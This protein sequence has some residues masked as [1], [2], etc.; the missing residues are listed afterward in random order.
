MDIWDFLARN[1]SN[2][3]QRYKKWL[4][5][6]SS[7]FSF[8]ELEDKD[9]KLVKRIIRSVREIYQE[10]GR[11]LV[12]LSSEHFFLTA[13]GEWT[14]LF[15][16]HVQLEWRAKEKEL[17]W[18]QSNSTF[19]I[20]PTLSS[21]Q[22]DL[23]GQEL[24]HWV[25]SQ[26]LFEPSK[27][28][29]GQKALF[30]D[31]NHKAYIQ[32]DLIQIQSLKMTSQAL[33]DLF[34][35]KIR[36]PYL[37]P[38]PDFLSLIHSVP[39]DYSQAEAID[40]AQRVSC[41]IAG[42]PG[43]GKS[44][45]IVNLAMQE[46]LSG[47]RV[48]VLSQKKVALDVLLNRMNA[49]GLNGF[50]LN[51]VYDSNLKEFYHS[52]ETTLESYLYE[53]KF[54]NDT[55]F[56]ISFFKHCIRTIEDYFIAKNY[57]KTKEKKKPVL[58]DFDTPSLS[59]SLLNFYYP[60]LSLMKEIPQDLINEISIVKELLGNLKLPHQLDFEFIIS[61]EQPLYLF[62][63]YDTNTLKKVLKRKKIPLAL[64]QIEKKIKNHIRVKPPENSLTKINEEKLEYYLKFLR[65]DKLWSKLYN[66]RAKEVTKEIIN[67][68]KHW[69]ELKLWDKMEQITGAL[70]YLQWESDYRR[71]IIEENKMKQET[72]GGGEA[73]GLKY[74]VNKLQSNMPSWSFVANYWINENNFQREDWRTLIQ[75]IKMIIR[76][77]PSIGGW[78]ISR[79]LELDMEAKWTLDKFSWEKL[80][81]L[82]F[83]SFEDWNM[84][85]NGHRPP[86]DTFPVLKNYTARELVR[87]AN[88][89]RSNY[90]DFTK[91]Q[92][93]SAL[94]LYHSGKFD[95]LSSLLKSRK[96]EGKEM[97]DLWKASIQF[98]QK[99]WSQKRT[100]PSLFQAFSRL[101]FNFLLWLK[102]LTIASLDKFSQYIPLTSELYDV[103][104]LDEASQIELLDSIPA[105]LRAKKVI[106]VGD[107]QQLTPSRFFK[108]QNFNIEEPHESIF[109]LAEEK[110]P[111]IQ[112]NYQYRAKH[113]ELIQYSNLHF[114]DN[115]L[116]TTNDSSAQAIK[117]VYLADG[118]YHN[119]KNRIEADQIIKELKTHLMGEKNSK[120]IG[121]ITFSIQQ[122][123]AILSKLE[124]ELMV[125][126]SF[127]DSL[128]NLDRSSEPFFVKSIE[129]VQG[130]ER[131][132]I[133][134]STGYGKNEQGK[135]YQ[136][137][138]PILT[139]KGE[140]RLNVLMS[141][142]REKIVFITSLRHTDI[143]ISSSSSQGLRMF[144]QLLIY[145]ENPIAALTSRNQ[146]EKNYWEYLINPFRK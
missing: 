88:F 68:N 42:P 108:Y 9:I 20:N 105:L 41:Y 61:L 5:I 112:L 136:F 78:T 133:L 119:R 84:Y 103:I 7:H 129:Q 40:L 97:R 73:E 4:D 25:D 63:Q 117:R 104:L 85:I 67:A 27:I 124:A 50:I 46:V 45:T 137:F 29:V 141:R 142:A 49:L 99:K 89:V 120:S 59:H 72:L 37:K 11:D 18:Q 1:T 39:M 80:C 53:Y 26:L 6:S 114:Y 15:F 70:T 138:G 90:T 135:I 56:N 83:K 19:F 143:Q 21:H 22:L 62:S 118:L 10:S 51:L 134:I 52:I 38:I 146:R 71:L 113:R 93:G 123:E 43:T 145:I 57:I 35:Q 64:G 126:K 116:V 31:L 121:I 30:F 111:A 28:K 140:N 75:L 32:K 16:T 96:Q 12:F 79:F 122:K 3:K 106:V 132:I 81:S 125:N 13:A 100:K 76:R 60:N 95:F 82:D 110:L 101:D 94:N 139:Y 8:K 115:K 128:N 58:V 44:Q 92:L 69:T 87:M 47:K 55:D 91:Y 14:P 102:P 17:H 74:I 66:P 107:S 33:Q 24:T 127:Q 86:L 109:E 65:E 48:A 77:N 130:D 36:M 34:N 54:K 23:S 2:T 131:D 144:K 98:V